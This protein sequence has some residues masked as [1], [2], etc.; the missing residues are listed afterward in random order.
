MKS[1]LSARQGAHVAGMALDAPR[2]AYKCS[3]VS[4]CHL[5]AHDIQACRVSASP[6]PSSFSMVTLCAVKA[7]LFDD[8]FLVVLGS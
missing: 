1:Q 5:I 7:F 3:L 6:G 8:T 2:D 4:I